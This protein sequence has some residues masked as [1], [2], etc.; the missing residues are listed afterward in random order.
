VVAVEWA[1]RLG[2]LLPREYL[3]VEIEIA[4]ESTR[5]FL[6]RGHGPRGEELVGRLVQEVADKGL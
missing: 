2:A 1:E 6:L 4:G 5:E 3:E